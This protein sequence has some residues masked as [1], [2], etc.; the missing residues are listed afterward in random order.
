MPVFAWMWLLFRGTRV[1]DYA[2]SF[3]TA[4][5]WFWLVPVLFFILALILTLDAHDRET[6]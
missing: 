4:V 6:G 2:A 5:G 3:Y 1:G